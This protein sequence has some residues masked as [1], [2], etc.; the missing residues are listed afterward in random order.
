MR[1]NLRYLVEDVDRYGKVRIYLRK[2]GCRKVA[3]K[4]KPGTPEFLVAYL[5]GMEIAQSEPQRQAPP[6]GERGSLRWLCTRYYGSAAYG[7]L[8]ARTRIVRKQILERL[9]CVSDCSDMDLGDKPYLE[10]KSRHIVAIRD[11][12][13]DRPEAANS[14]V[15]ALRRLFAWAKEAGHVESNPAI[16]I[17][18]LQA[19]NPEGFHT[20]T[21][22]EVRRFERHH[23]LGTK[24]RLA[25][26]LLL[27]LGVRRS[28]VVRLG[29]QMMHGDALHFVE[30][31]GRGKKRTRK[32]RELP[33]LPELREA[34][35]ACN[36]N[37]PTFLV[38]EFGKPYTANGFGNWFRRR[39][40]EAGL[41]HCS[42]HGLRKAAATIAAENNAT[43]HQLMAIFGWESLKQ[44]ELYTRK[45]DRNRL[46]RAGMHLIVPRENAEIV[47]GVIPGFVQLPLSH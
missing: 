19:D 4:G 14:I 27:Y 21:V 26:A 9:C 13:A 29:R 42:A 35:D 28:D 2:P 23:P 38:T 6:R 46:A 30:F 33:I 1:F 40:R 5:A 10:M 41:D 43:A 7:Q 45:A 3:I 32:E 24:A 36:S 44:A 47:Q 11:A 25:M 12:H 31:K 8:G 16:E 34:I 22:Q 18:Y 17:G 39:C 37:D 20:W 15:K